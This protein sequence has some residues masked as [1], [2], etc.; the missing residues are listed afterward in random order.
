MNV[1]KRLASALL[2]PVFAGCLSAHVPDVADWNVVSVAAEARPAAKVPAFGV[3]RLAQVV[4]CSPYD[5][6][7]MLVYRSDNTLASDPCNLF[8]ATPSRLLREPARAALA[9]SGK[10]KAVV[11]ASS[12][13]NASHVVELT[14]TDLRL[15]CS[16]GEGDPNRREAVAEVFVL[17]LN[18]NRDIVGSA[19]G[20]ARAPAGDGDFGKAFSKA[21]SSA[22]ADALTGL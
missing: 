4:V 22:L 5:A 14:V 12:S 13:A 19:R 6:R 2:L 1:M 15:D 16:N 10:F 17:V 11:G 3:A 7:P 8:A 21:F 18:A 9:S 20:M